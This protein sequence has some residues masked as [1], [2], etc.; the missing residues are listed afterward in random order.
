MPFEILDKIFDWIRPVNHLYPLLLS[1]KKIFY[2]AAKLLYKSP[3]PVSNSK[4]RSEQLLATL[5]ASARET[6]FFPYL[7][8]VNTLAAS[9]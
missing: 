7:L 3:S 9:D 2:M 4:E 8:Q 1:N 6:S 5:T